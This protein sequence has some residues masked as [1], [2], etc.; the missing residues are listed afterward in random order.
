MFKWVEASEVHCAWCVPQ[1]ALVCACLG[2]G[3][4][5]H[6]VGDTCALPT[7]QISVPSP[8]SPTHRCLADFSNTPI[9][10]I[11]MFRVGVGLLYWLGEKM[12]RVSGCRVCKSMLEC[13]CV[14]GPHVCVRAANVRLF[15]PQCGRDGPTWPTQVLAL[16]VCFLV[17]SLRDDACSFIEIQ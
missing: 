12:Q 4:G 8:A 13:Y 10:V 5:C 7:P 2:A 15:A 1:S 9:Y 3:Q 14:R 16:A 17:R 6:G 11:C